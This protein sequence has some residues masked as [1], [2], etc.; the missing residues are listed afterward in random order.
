MQPHDFKRKYRGSGASYIKQPNGWH[1][2]LLRIA[3]GF[4][5][6]HVFAVAG[7]SASL[8][9]FVAT[10]SKTEANNRK[11]IDDLAIPALETLPEPTNVA[12]EELNAE[13]YELESRLQQ[14]EPTRIKVQSGDNLSLVFQRAGLNDRDVYEI[15]NSDK[16]AKRLKQLYPGNIFEFTIEKIK[17]LFPH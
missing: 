12:S 15:L 17:Q 14:K 6:G 9:L 13:L 3:R 10:P 1:G 2:R 8:V 16:E 11:V 5:K 7:L 4:P